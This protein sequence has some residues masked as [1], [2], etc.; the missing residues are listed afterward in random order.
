MKM[1]AYFFWGILLIVIGL[2]IILKVAF[3]IDIIRFV[4][5]IF[6]ILIG[7][8]MLTGIVINDH[9]TRNRDAFFSN[10]RY[11]NLD[12]KEYNLVFGRNVF[13][14]KDLTS[15]ELSSKQVQINTV[16]GASFVR[17][18]PDI[19]VKIKANVIFGHVQ[20]PDKTRVYFGTGNYHSKDSMADEAL[21]I[22]ANVVFGKIE[23]K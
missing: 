10:P 7:I 16:F 3:Q 15:D 20:M 5:A 8:K 22:E 9:Q 6:F 4:V 13:D 19:P 12:Q 21:L 11:N 23:F 14:L 18:S 1:G 2:S 17:L